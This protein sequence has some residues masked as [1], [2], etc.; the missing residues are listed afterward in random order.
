MRTNI[1]TFVNF[2]SDSRCHLN[3]F[4]FEPKISGQKRNILIGN[5]KIQINAGYGWNARKKYR[6]ELQP[7]VH[8]PIRR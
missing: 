1:K 6:Q 5:F 8:G 2:M 4:N 3:K 7:K